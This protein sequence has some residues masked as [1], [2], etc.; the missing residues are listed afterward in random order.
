MLILGI[1]LFILTQ[2]LFFSIYGSLASVLLNDFKEIP[3]EVNDACK[4]TV[5]PNLQ[6]GSLIYEAPEHILKDYKVKIDSLLEK[7]TDRLPKLFPLLE[8]APCSECKFWNAVLRTNFRSFYSTFEEFIAEK[9]N[10]G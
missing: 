5:Y 1:V 3:S 4:L 10:L 6:L 8:E 7:P 2:I 9:K